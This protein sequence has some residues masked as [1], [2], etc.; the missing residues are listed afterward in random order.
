MEKKLGFHIVK[1]MNEERTEIGL[2]FNHIEFVEG[3][4]Y[5]VTV[6]LELIDK[7]TYPKV[8]AGVLSNK[9]I[10]SIANDL[11]GRNNIKES[12]VTYDYQNYNINQ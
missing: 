11:I 6:G 3:S 8:F 5:N 1:P 4:D 7:E 12:A 2:Y 9:D 10:D